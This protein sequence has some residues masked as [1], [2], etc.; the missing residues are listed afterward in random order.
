M[1]VKEGG[2]DTSCYWGFR[3]SYGEV[4]Q[5][6]RKDGSTTKC[7]DAAETL[8]PWNSMNHQKSVRL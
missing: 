1:K 8:F 5:Q 2:I 4:K 6:H 3:N 7:I